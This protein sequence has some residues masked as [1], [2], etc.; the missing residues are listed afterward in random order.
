M[1]RTHTKQ[2]VTTCGHDDGNRMGQHFVCLF[3]SFATDKRI[4][5]HRHL[6][7]E[8]YPSLLFIGMNLFS[9][10]LLRSAT[11]RGGLRTLLI[12]YFATL[13]RHR[14]PLNFYDLLQIVCKGSCSPPAR[15]ESPFFFFF[16][17]FDSFEIWKRWKL[18]CFLLSL[19]F[20][21]KFIGH[22]VRLLIV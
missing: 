13:V 4:S 7:R 1:F 20:Y 18:I 19:L 12:K 17:L 15:G 9:E 22:L 8:C 11:W 2:Q 5:L 3:A 14:S 21:R 6:Y 10:G 16:F